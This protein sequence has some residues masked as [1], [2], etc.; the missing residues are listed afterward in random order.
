MKSVFQLTEIIEFIR[1]SEKQGNCDY[2]GSDNVQI[3]DVEDVGFFIQEGID[4]YYEDAAEHV[5][6]C[7]ADSGYQMATKTISEILIEEEEIFSDLID[8]PYILQESLISEDATPYVRVNPYGDPSGDPIEIYY[9]EIFCNIVKEKQRY[10]ALI[11]F[12]DSIFDHDH[13]K[14]FF[15]R[16]SDYFMPSLIRTIEPGE[17]IYRARIKKSEKRFSH[18]D[19]TSPPN[20]LTKAGRMNPYGISFFYGSLDDYKTTIHEVRPDI[21]ESIAVATF[22]TQ[23]QLNVLDLSQKIESR[24]SIFDSNYFFE[25]EEYFKPFLQYFSDTIARPIRKSDVDL[26]Y[27]PTQVFIEY[28]KNVNLKSQYF[29][30]NED[31]S[32]SD[33]YIDGLIYKSSVYENGVNIVLFRGSDISST[34]SK[35]KKDSWLI[36][37]SQKPYIISNIHIISN[38]K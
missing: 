6:F 38:P 16:L 10:T 37:C 15:S 36:Y 28:I 18:K 12:K 27:I 31:G 8:D 19:L 21:G 17:K 34:K 33:V 32:A 29:I 11:D 25:H 24:R 3:A 9:W 26:E 14:D 1:N 23:K 2:C 13:P 4:R 30:P 7:S 35:K 20:S 22:Q 5:T